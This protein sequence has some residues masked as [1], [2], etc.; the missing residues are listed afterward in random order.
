MSTLLWRWGPPATTGV[1]VLVL[2]IVSFRALDE[3]DALRAELAQLRAA[4][5]RLEEDLDGRITF[6]ELRA[7]AELHERSEGLQAQ[8]EAARAE[9][10][11]L[12]AHTL[13]GFEEP[14]VVSATYLTPPS[15]AANQPI[16]LYVRDGTAM[17]L[18]IDLCARYT[19][20]GSEG[21]SCLASSTYSIDEIFDC[22][23]RAEVGRPLP[24]C[25]P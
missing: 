6:V 16:I 8:L 2:A 20:S 15:K 9:I 11:E 24:G 4:L 18:Y 17:P 19:R 3:M 1:I 10:A 5:A 25:F 12:R 13:A 22:F 14:R 23:E 7:L 21:E